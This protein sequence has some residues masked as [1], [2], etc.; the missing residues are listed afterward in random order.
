[1][2]VMFLCDVCAKISASNTDSQRALG[3]TT[4]GWINSVA[5]RR[6]HLRAAYRLRLFR[7]VVNFTGWLTVSQRIVVKLAVIAYRCLHRLELTMVRWSTQFSRWTLSYLVN[8]DLRPASSSSLIV[9]RTRLSTRDDWQWFLHSRSLPVP[10]SQ[11]PLLPIPKFKSYFHSRPIL[12]RTHSKTIKCKCK[13]ST[14][15]QQNSS[16]ENWTSVGEAQFAIF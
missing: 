8:V 14:V 11:H 13:L 10:C 7:R 2:S 9:R 4:A 15:E 16:T 5:R 12:T 6:R 1:M 3:S